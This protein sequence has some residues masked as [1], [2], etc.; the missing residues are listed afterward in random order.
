M[1][2]QDLVLTYN[3]QTRTSSVSLSKQSEPQQ[4]VQSVQQD[5][6]HLLEKGAGKIKLKLIREKTLI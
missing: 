6:R 3:E 4:P 1:P 2:N 5:S